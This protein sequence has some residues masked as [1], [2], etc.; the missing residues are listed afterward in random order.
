MSVPQKQVKV[1]YAYD[2]AHDDE[3]TIR[4]GMFS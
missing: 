1:L 2:A 4:P 3:L